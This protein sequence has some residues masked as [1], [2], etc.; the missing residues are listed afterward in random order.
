[1]LV[2]AKAGARGIRIP[3]CLSRVVTLMISKFFAETSDGDYEVAG[4]CS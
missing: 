2:A 3:H 1:M 4:S